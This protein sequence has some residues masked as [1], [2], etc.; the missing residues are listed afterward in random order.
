MEFIEGQPLYNYCDANQLN[1]TDRLKLFN[2]LR[3]C[4]LRASE[5]G[6]A[7]GHQTIQRFGDRGRSAEAPG[8]WHR[9]VAQ[10]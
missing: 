8:F 7:P 10:S 4:S 2:D 5:T 3:R 9:K 1:I 6:R